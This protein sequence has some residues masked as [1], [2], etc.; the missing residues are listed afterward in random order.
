MNE[1]KVVYRADSLNDG[2]SH[3]IEWEHGCPLIFDAFQV[4]RNTETGEAFL[5]ARVRNICGDMVSAFSASFRCKYKDGF[6]EVLTVNPLDSDIVTGG[7]YSVQPMRLS[8]GDIESASAAICSAAL[9]SGGWEST[10]KPSKYPTR[11]ELGICGEALAERALQLEKRGC[12]QSSSSA[13]FPVEEHPGWTLCACGQPNVETGKCLNCGLSP[14]EADSTI[15]DDCSLLELARVRAEEKERLEEEAK[16]RKRAFQ[17]RARRIAPYLATCIAV[18]AVVAFA[19]IVIIPTMER[20]KA[21]ALI[22][23]GDYGAAIEAFEAMGDEEGVQRAKSAQIECEYQE[24]LSLLESKDYEA[25]LVAFGRLEDYKDSPEKRALAL[26][27]VNYTKAEELEKAG[28]L[29][30]AAI[31]FGRLDDYGDAAERSNKLWDQVVTGGKI[32]ASG[33]TLAAVLPDGTVAVLD[34]FSTTTNAF[35]ES[36]ARLHDVASVAAGGAVV[37]VMQD[38]DVSYATIPH[39]HFDSTPNWSDV[40]S[41]SASESAVI[42]LLSD[43]TVEVDCYLHN[44]GDFTTWNNVMDVTTCGE[45]AVLALRTDGTVLVEGALDL[46]YDEAKAIEGWTDIVDIDGGDC[47]VVGAKSDGTVTCEGIWFNEDIQ[48]WTDIVSVSAGDN[49]I[50]GMKSDG[51]A[52]VSHCPTYEEDNDISVTGWPG[53]IEVSAGDGFV[54]G[55]GADGAVYYSGEDDSWRLGECTG[56]KVVTAK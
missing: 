52:V 55:L 9:S 31:E 33:S 21:D 22:R 23:S 39:G 37:G 27:S 25:A 48:H 13:P 47:F 14:L 35:K 7:F 38:G 41:V 53:L 15:E 17:E 28:D 6:E 50:V 18:V 16:Q 3:G 20:S 10:S 56:W 43:G 2:S 46:D 36:I 30:Q 11:T 44:S 12:K 54:V 42:A 34:K 24:A 45:G 26:K 51:T 8:Q 49:V 19:S 4:S 32:S 1:Y 29:T 5:Q 40:V